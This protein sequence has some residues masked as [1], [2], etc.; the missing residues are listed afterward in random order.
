MRAIIEGPPA[1]GA[2]GAPPLWK[3]LA[4]FMGIALASAGATALVAWILHAL[5]PSP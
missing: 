3:R 1:P 5:L 2:A 4:W